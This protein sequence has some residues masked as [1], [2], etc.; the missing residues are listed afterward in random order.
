M[1]LPQFA[2]RL[3]L[4]LWT[5][6]LPIAAAQQARYPGTLDV[7]Y[8]PTNHATVEAMLRIA[9][10]GPNDFVIDLGSGDGRILITAARKYGARGM[11]VDLDPQRVKE[12]MA[13]AKDADITQKYQEI[14]VIARRGGRQMLVTDARMDGDTIAFILTEA[15]DITSRRRFEG[16]VTGNAMEGTVR[17]DASA[18]GEYKWRASK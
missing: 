9:A 6:A 17:S 11:G 14:N 2:G 10:V 3:C 5:L 12:S 7:P 16:R 4:L 18:R 13:N 8:V 15:D 1:V